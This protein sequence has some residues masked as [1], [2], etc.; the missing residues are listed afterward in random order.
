MRGISIGNSALFSPDGSAL[1]LPNGKHNESALNAP[2][3]FRIEYS[4]TRDFGPPMNEIAIYMTAVTALEDLCFRDQDT[5]VPGYPPVPIHS[6]STWSLEQYDI[7]LEI[8]SQKVRYAIWGLQCTAG[9]ILKVGLWPVIGRYFWREQFAGRLDFANKK[10]PLPPTNRDSFIQQQSSASAEA[11]TNSKITASPASNFSNITLIAD[12][13]D[14]ARL[15]IVP[16]YHGVLLSPRAVFGSAID[17][18]VYGAEY[19]LDTYCLRLQRAGLDV[20]GQKDAAG[21]PLLKY[22]SLIRAMAMLMPWMVAMNRFGEINVEIR[23][24]AV[25]VGNVRIQKRVR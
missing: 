2:S 6:P 20:F 9:D 4:S 5:P 23:R 15:T 16:T 12:S 1:I 3:D 24:D 13:V 17:A 19:G 11:R 10:N 25:L 18:M 14:G 8:S 7:Y 22:K 21:E